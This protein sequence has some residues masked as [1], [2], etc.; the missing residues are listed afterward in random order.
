MSQTFEERF[1]IHPED[2]KQYSTERIRNEFLIDN[3][4]QKDHI[5]LVYSH[6]DR[7]IV[8]G[9]VPEKGKLTLETFDL[10]K[11]DSFLE[12]RELGAVNVGGEGKVTVDGEVYTL[13]KKEAIYVGQGKKE[14]VFES[15]SQNDPAYFYLNSA[16]AH[17]AYPVKH[18]TRKDAEVVNLGSLDTSNERTINKLIVNSVTGICQMQMGL[19][20]LSPGSVWNTMPPHTH[21]RRMEAYFYFD[22]PEDQAVAHFMGEPQESRVLWLRNRQAILSPPWSMHMGAGTSN[23]SFIWGMAGENLDYGDMDGVTPIELK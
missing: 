22:L 2:F 9:A 14:V 7:Y 16:P 12:R 5:H 23:Y 6:Y 15:S 18:I 1:A 19:T 10:L 3:L 17:H 8:G 20:E 4:F 21:T 11:A 13:K